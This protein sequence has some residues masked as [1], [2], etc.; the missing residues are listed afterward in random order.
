MDMTF[1][2][3]IAN[4]MGKNNAVLNAST[5][6]IM[7]KTYSQKF[8][9][10]L[11]REN[12]KITYFLY[13]D[14][15][16]NTYWAHIKVPSETVKDFYYDVVLKF[17]A[18]S[19]ISGAGNDLFKYHVQFYSND[20]SFVYTYAHVFLKNNLF[21]KELASKMSK[22][23][24]RKEAK[25]K[26]PNNNVGYVKTLYFA[27]LIMQNKGLNKKIKFDAEAKELD[28]AF[29]YSQIEN[30]EDKIKKREEEGSKVSKKK[31]VV[32]DKN[33]ANRVIHSLNGNT[34]GLEGLQ[35]KTTKRVNVKSSIPSSKQTKRV[36]TIKKK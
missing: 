18:D 25:E 22:Q 1:D 9:N 30:A 6:E 36:G 35:V 15:K 20:P 28:K 17:S 7:R 11:L 33:T 24:L 26:N 13:K 27:Y 29:L 23:A 21:I 10:L 3:Y 34:A 4:P 16:S 19:D 14:K 32:L 2:Q 12:G 31:K 5:R 8:D